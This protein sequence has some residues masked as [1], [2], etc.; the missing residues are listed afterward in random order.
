MKKQR[1]TNDFRENW[2]Y[3]FQ[4]RELKERIRACQMCGT[5]EKLE[6]HHKIPFSKGGTEIEENL[7]VVCDSCHKKIHKIKLR[8]SKN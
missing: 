4:K 1:K 3:R 2:L 8:K 6:I 7:L 5:D